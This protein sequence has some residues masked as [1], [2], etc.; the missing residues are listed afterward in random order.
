M[1]SKKIYIGRYITSKNHTSKLLADKK[2]ENNGQADVINIENS[3]QII[4]S[5]ELFYA[6]QNLKEN[7]KDNKV[8]INETCYQSGN[9][10]IL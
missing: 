10:I 1:L 8:N 7:I 6:V 5:K 2:G 4:I 3:Y 9:S